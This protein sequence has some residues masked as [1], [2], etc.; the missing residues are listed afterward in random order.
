MSNYILAVDKYR[1]GYAD[2]AR[3]VARY[4]ATPETLSFHNV[5]NLTDAACKARLLRHLDQCIAEIDNEIDPQES[6]SNGIN[7]GTES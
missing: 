5:P 2:C 3:E 4:L 7:K 6:T 1:A